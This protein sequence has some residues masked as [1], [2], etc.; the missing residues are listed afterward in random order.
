MNPYNAATIETALHD[1]IA[2]EGV[3]I[4]QLIHPLRI[5]VTGQ[6][7]GF[8]LFETLA[9]LGRE[10]SARRIEHTLQRCHDAG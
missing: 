3:Q 9:I 10:S 1:F 4:G 6:P 5:A 8:G 7:V 2:A